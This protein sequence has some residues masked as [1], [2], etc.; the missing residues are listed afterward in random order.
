MKFS[1]NWLQSF[2]DKPLPKPRELAELL[3]M[4]SFEVEEVSKKSDDWILDIDILPNRA[5]DCL[6]HF[7]VARECSA[8][9]KLKMKNEKFKTKIQNLKSGGRKY[10]DV[11]IAS[12]DLCPRYSAYVIEGV[13][14][15]DSPGWIKER[16]AAMGQKPINNVVDITNYIMWESGQPLHAF[17]FAKIKGGKMIVRESKKG[18]KLETLDGAKHDLGSDIIVIEDSERIIDL[19]GIK[20]GANTQVD[21]NTATIIFQAAIFDSA[22]IRK[23]SQKLGVKT[24]ASV[25]YMH[26]FDQ[27]L[28]PQALERAVAVLRETN[29]DVK[30][31]QKIDIYPNPAKPKKITI[32]TRYVNGLLGTDI[33]KKKMEQILDTLGFTLPSFKMGFKFKD[34]GFKF[35]VTVPA[36]RLDINIPEDVIEEIGR[37][38]GYENIEPA[39]PLGILIAPRRNEQVF[40]R[41]KAREIL[42]GF[43]FSETYNYSMM[44]ER[45]AKGYALDLAEVANPVSDEFQYMRP[46]LLPGLLKNMASNAKY[47]SKV[48]LFEVGRVLFMDD[49]DTRE[50]ENFA[51]A[52]SGDGS[53]GNGF[54]EVKGYAD[55]FLKKLGVADFYFDPAFSKEEI[56]HG[57]LLHPARRA[58]M[59][60]DGKPAGF[61]G[62]V[63]PNLLAKF[64][65]KTRVYFAEFNFGIISAAAEE[66]HIYQKPSKYP[67]VVRDIAV[68]VPSGTTVEEVENTVNGVSGPLLRDVDLFDMYEGENISEGMKNLAFHLLFQ[69]DERTLTSQEV[70]QIMA[71]ITKALE[72]NSWEVR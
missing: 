31:V 25:R 33:S 64:A 24:D 39:A 5:H 26:G 1:Y 61:V 8:L 10:L 11:K 59:R 69:S 60:L 58:I 70:D 16:L 48:K 44:A 30:I 32:D 56:Y 18:E 22:H 62:E 46:R 13:K 71:K 27:A 9:A 34:L 50:E 21:N 36:Y 57:S 43:G 51:M 35:T 2:F 66:E 68:L 47:F 40:W 65:I 53:N 67:E 3:T 38:H 23:T 41:T 19:A 15:T 4:H 6:G 37:V 29:P 20:G 72:D 49:K 55:E 12:A 28:P 45:H 52:L 17:D 54:Y 42:S 63:H 7:G 14:I